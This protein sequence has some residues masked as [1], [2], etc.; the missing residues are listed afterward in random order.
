MDFATDLRFVIVVVSNVNAYWAIRFII[1]FN[2]ISYTFIVNRSL[3][4][5]L[6]NFDVTNKQTNKLQTHSSL[7]FYLNLSS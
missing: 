1:L 5:I 7:K 2:A 3:N 4:E 6:L